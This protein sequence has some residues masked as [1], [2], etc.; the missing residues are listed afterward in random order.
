MQIKSIILRIKNIFTI[1]SGKKQVLLTNIIITIIEYQKYNDF[2]RFI[3]LF[4]FHI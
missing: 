4:D 1:K 3:I 2:A